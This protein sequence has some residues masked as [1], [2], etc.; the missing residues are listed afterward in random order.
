MR[1]IIFRGL[2][3]GPPILGNY[4]IRFL[5]QCCVCGFQLVA[6]SLEILPGFGLGIRY[7]LG[8][9]FARL[10]PQNPKPWAIKGMEAEKTAWL[11]RLSAP[12]LSSS[13]KGLHKEMGFGV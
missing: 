10:G 7:N 13:T 1:N 5:R 6:P 4:H 9:K 3:W 11:R 12:I 2:H 8:S